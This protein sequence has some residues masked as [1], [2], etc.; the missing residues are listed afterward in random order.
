MSI[1]TVNGSPV[2]Y[3]NKWLAPGGT[4]DLPPYDSTD[5]GKA[6]VVNNEGDNVEWQTV[7]S[8]VTV[9]QHYDSTSSNPQSGT[10][11]A[12]AVGSINQVPSSSPS[13]SGKVLT[14]NSSGNAEWITPSGGTTYTQ[15]NMISLANDQIAV[16]TTAGVTDIQFVNALPAN[17][18]AT[19]LYL[20]PVV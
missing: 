2:K 6:L 5:A 18:V 11:V 4:H 1:Y 15:G 20:I 7:G 16:S 3:D 14:V 8:T 13:D 19:V 12:E 9:D 17:P 10:A